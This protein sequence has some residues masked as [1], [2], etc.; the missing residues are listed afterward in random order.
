MDWFPEFVQKYLTFTGRC[1]RHCE[2]PTSLKLTSQDSS[3][4]MGAYVCPDGVVSQVVYFSMKPDLTWFENLLS[5]QAGK[6]NVSSRD[7]R[8][9]TRHGWE[10]GGDAEATLQAKL[11]PGALIKEVYWKRYPQTDTQ[12]EQLLSL[13][14]GNGSRAGCMKLFI[15]HKDS[16]EKL[17]P[18]CRAK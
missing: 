17:C 10:L 15:H 13:C 8:V 3:H 1:Y 2:R 9:A 16:N 5:S 18:V 14:L 7:I 11:G 12:K 6:E 4:V